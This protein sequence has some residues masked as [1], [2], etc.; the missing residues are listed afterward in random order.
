MPGALLLILLCAAAPAVALLL[1][2][3]QSLILLLLLLKLHA[4]LLRIRWQRWLLLL[5]LLLLRLLRLGAGA[6]VVGRSVGTSVN[7]GVTHL[8][9]LLCRSRW[10]LLSLRQHI[11]DLSDTLPR[12]TLSSETDGQIYYN[13]P[14]TQSS[15]MANWLIGRNCVRNHHANVPQSDIPSMSVFEDTCTTAAYPMATIDTV[16]RQPRSTILPTSGIARMGPTRSHTH[17]T[18]E[19]TLT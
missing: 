13:V 1:L 5:L 17:I 7:D 18:Q 2:L 19:S 10:F 9:P 4:R 14:Q 12:H 8:A 3:L 16:G 11:D 15:R 6:R